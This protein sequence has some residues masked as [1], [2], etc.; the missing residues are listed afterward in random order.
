VLSGCGSANRS[1]SAADAF[2]TRAFQVVGAWDQAATAAGYGQGVRLL[3]ASTVP[4]ASGFPSED[5][6]RQYRAGAYRLRTTLRAETPPMGTVRQADGTTS[7]V[8]VVPAT[9]A[10]AGLTNGAPPC[11]DCQGLTVTGAR[12][13][14]ATVRTNRGAATVPV[15]LF[16]V[17]ELHD[18]VARVAVSVDALRPLPSPSPPAA[19]ASL[20]LTSVIDVVPDPVGSDPAAA[21]RLTVRL[22]VSP[23]DVNPH[24]SV[25]EASDAV[26]IG[27]QRTPP[28]P[29]K[30]CPDLLQVRPFTVTLSQPLADRVLL[31]A[32]D[33]Q[34]VPLGAHQP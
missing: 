23:C 7:T 18:P 32:S 31:N 5:V 10:Y 24:P 19:P 8:P 17:A 4:P 33:G 25:Y 34:P 11:T 30:A 20:H 28:S 27:G 2:V 16:D 29:G 21:T 9:E 6:A 1:P 13:G 14:T 12:L 22:G 15:W 26:V 3:D